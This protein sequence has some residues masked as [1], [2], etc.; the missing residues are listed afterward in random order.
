MA[1]MGDW[2]FLLEIDGKPGMGG[3]FYNRGWEV[4]KV[5]LHSW[6]RGANPPIL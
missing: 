4:F 6:N 2:K 1:V 5:C 3:W